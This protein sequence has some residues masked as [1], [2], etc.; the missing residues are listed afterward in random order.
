MMRKVT[1]AAAFARD[2][3]RATIVDRDN[4][5]VAAARN[6]GIA[7]ST[8]AY[9]APID[10]DDVWHPGYLD[11]M[12]NKLTDAATLPT[13]AYAACRL[14]D[15]QSRVIGTGLDASAEGPLVYRMLYCNVVGNGR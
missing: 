7:A 8:G 10:A 1:I 14:I 13:F 12:L 5:G 11:K 9:I 2:D 15:A 3:P 4:G 6:A